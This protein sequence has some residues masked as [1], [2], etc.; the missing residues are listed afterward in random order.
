MMVEG[1][2]DRMRA[3]PRA[4]PLAAFLCLTMLATACSSELERTPAERAVRVDVDRCGTSSGTFGSGVIVDDDRVL[5]TA[6]TLSR[7][8]RPVVT[9]HVGNAHRATLIGL[10]L[11][12][13]LALLRVENLEASPVAFATADD[14]TTGVIHGGA[15]SGTVE[16]R[17]IRSANITIDQVLTDE[18]S[19]R[20]GYEIEADTERG[21]SGAGVYD[22]SGELVGI[23]FAVSSSGS[24][25][26]VTAS[27]VIA[28]F[29]DAAASSDDVIECDP[30]QSRVGQPSN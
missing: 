5:T 26:W 16:H 14:G 7:G 30:A 25:T 9:D 2:A 3:H 12:N 4:R 23:V 29:L 18:A 8:S 28:R 17:V 27:S 15:V 10:D 1:H 6:H 24:S 13:D 19:T 22:G 20:F 21:D 11:V